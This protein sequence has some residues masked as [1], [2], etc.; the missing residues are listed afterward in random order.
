M[1]V[2]PPAQPGWSGAA[3]MLFQ[4]HPVK[5]NIFLR[6]ISPVSLYV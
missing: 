4:I 5:E 2:V 1:G 6:L 3:E